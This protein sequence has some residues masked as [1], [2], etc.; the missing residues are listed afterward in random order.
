MDYARVYKKDAKRL[1]EA[2]SSSNILSK[3]YMVESDDT[4]VYF[5]VTDK[6]NALTVASSI[7]IDII[8]VALPGIIKQDN[9]IDHTLKELLGDDYHDIKRGFDIVGDIA[10]IEKTPGHEDKAIVIANA[11]MEHHK[12]VKGVYAKEGIHEGDYRIQ[13][14]VHVIGKDSKETCHVENGYRIFLEVGSTYFS[15][16]LS[17]ERLRIARMVNDNER[18]L[19]LFSG[20]APYGIAINKH[21]KA[22]RIVCVELN[23]KAHEYALINVEKNKA[24]NVECILGDANDAIMKMAE[25]N[26]VFDRIIMP[27]PK[28]ADDYLVPISRLCNDNTMIH[29]Y[30]FCEEAMID[31]NVNERLSN[32]LGEVAEYS[33]ENI[34]RVGAYS[35]GKMRVCADVRIIRMLQ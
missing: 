13:G 11:I 30:S 12:S 33:I 23:P 34:Q 1:K 17:Q 15:P 25:D 6:D 5:P 10:V 4:Y 14:I 2:Y 32:T 27:L 29:W 31:N 7:N 18:V 24:Y 35:P 26:V 8:I 20:V 28:T 3:D 22:N 16:R 9:N 19:V 21:S